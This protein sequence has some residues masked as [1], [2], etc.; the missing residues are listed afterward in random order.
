MQSNRVTSYLF[1]RIQEARQ[2]LGISR[3]SLYAFSDPKSRS[4]RPEF[5]KRVHQGYLV[6]FMDHELDAY[7]EGLMAARR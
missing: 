6:G 7:I 3:S 4:F 5:L 2:R 1:V